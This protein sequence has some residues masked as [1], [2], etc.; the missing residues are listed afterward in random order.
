M[1][2]LRKKGLMIMDPHFVGSVYPPSVQAEIEQDVEFLS[3][4]LSA[5]QVQ[6]DPSILE[7]VELVF[8]G[9]GGLR[10]DEALLDAAPRL[11][12][13]FHAAGSIKPIVTPTFWER[14][15]EITSAYDANAVPVAQYALS[16]ILFSLKCGWQ[17]VHK[18]Q[19]D[20]AYPPKPYGHLAGGY[21]SRVGL[22]SY[23]TVG[24]KVRNYLRAF[25]I[26]V[27][28]YDPFLD[29]RAAAEEEIELCTLKALFERAD[30]LSLHTPLLPETVGLITGDHFAAMKPYASFINTARGAIVEEDALIEVF[31]K[32]PDLTAILDVTN[33]EPPIQG[34]PLFTLPN[35]VLTPHIA[36]SE[37][38]ECGRMGAYMLAECRNY[39][40]GKPLQWR[41]SEEKSRKMA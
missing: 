7:N 41:I 30:V 17:F 31:R 33:P 29:E 1:S 13:V 11:E 5:Q 37:G 22:I 6:Q 40:A 12:A 26:D 20:Q 16:Q 4:P 38:A 34:S 27:L 19:S 15:I 39:I 2:A 14:G 3:S 24:R 25:D 8:S 9:W 10:W 18:V 36:G 32:R 35:I 21:G 28:V 23:S